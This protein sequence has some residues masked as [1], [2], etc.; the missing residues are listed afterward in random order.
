MNSHFQIAVVRFG[1][2]QHRQDVAEL[3]A[4]GIPLPYGYLATD[5]LSYSAGAHWIRVLGRNQAIISGFVV[6]TSMSRALPG[7]F[8]GR[9]DRIGRR[10]HE[11]LLANLGAILLEAALAIP[12]LKRLNA[13]IFDED[14]ER[15]TRMLASIERTG[16]DVPV[17]WARYTRTIVTYVGGTVGLEWP[18]MT[19]TA[20]YNL[21]RFSRTPQLE[22]RPIGDIHYAGRMRDLFVSTFERTGGTAPR[23][24]MRRRIEDAVHCTRSRLVGVYFRDRA[25]PMDLV[26]F[27]RAELHGDHA[28]Y[29]EGASERSDDFRSQPL[30]YPLMVDLLDWTRSSGGTWFDF[31]GIPANEPSSNPSLAGIT[32]FKRQFS[33]TELDIAREAAL[34]P[35]PALDRV[36][37][38]VRSIARLVRR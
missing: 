35:R 21:N 25:P 29:E 3:T 37:R 10:L 8:V 23:I 5:S 38:T 32:Q 7:T 33:R 9:I 4:A 14:G 11:P 20:R 34:K 28:C 6:Q 31:G 24:D 16:G 26:A 27:M 12:R 22:V 30:G 13:R 1:S 36:A 18:S 15:R 19:K 2:I 17:H